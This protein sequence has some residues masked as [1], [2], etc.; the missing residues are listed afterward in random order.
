MQEMSTHAQ[1]SLVRFDARLC[2]LSLFVLRL[3]NLLLR[4]LLARLQVMCER[5]RMA[6]FQSGVLFDVLAAFVPISLGLSRSEV[7]E[8]SVVTFCCHVNEES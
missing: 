2:V 7:P 5:I 3:F 4:S 1:L 8:L 6:R